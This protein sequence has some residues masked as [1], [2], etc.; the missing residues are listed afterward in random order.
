MSHVE[1]CNWTVVFQDW[2]EA[3]PVVCPGDKLR[4]LGGAFVPGRP[5]NSCHE[6]HEP[7]HT[8]GEYSEPDKFQFS[9]GST[10]L[11]WGSNWLQKSFQSGDFRSEVQVC[12]GTLL[13]YQSAEKPLICLFVQNI[14][15]KT[16]YDVLSTK[17]VLNKVSLFMTVC[18]YEFKASEII[19]V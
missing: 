18:T 11:K 3:G 10:E 17:P 19:S 8:E 6:V 13:F 16:M 9:T 12:Q 2:P 5:Q 14:T 1:V 4:P 7:D 15:L